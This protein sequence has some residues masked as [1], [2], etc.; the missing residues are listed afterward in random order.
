MRRYQKPVLHAIVGRGLTERDAAAWRR[1][2]VGDH[3]RVAGEADGHVGGALIGEDLGLRRRVGLHR[4]VPVEVI[5]RQVEPRRRL[6]A[7]V[8]GPGQPEARALDDEDVDVE[9]DRLDEG[10]VGISCG[11]GPHPRGFQDGDREQGRRRLPVGPGDGEHRPGAVV[12]L[13]LPFIGQLQLAHDAPALIAGHAEQAVALGNAW[14][15]N[16]EVAVLDEPGQP[17]VVR[18]DQQ[19]D[20]EIVSQVAPL[21]CIEVVGD[22]D[23]VPPRGECPHGRCPS[24]RQPVHQGALRHGVM[25]E[26]RVKSP[27]KIPRAAATDTAAIN[28][29]RMMTVVS[30]Q[31][32]SSKWW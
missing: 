17:A 8:L 21:R 13:L 15:R 27:M 24:Y 2:Q 7:E 1:R 23:V 16:D 6:A 29:K 4:L 25:S 22:D 18:G 12:A 30:G 32:T 11:N 3:R 14:R 9:V 26:T 19:V 31:P 5:G 28:Q 20:T 10:H